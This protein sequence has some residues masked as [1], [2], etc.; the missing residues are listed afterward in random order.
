MLLINVIS[1]A[2]GHWRVWATMLI[3]FRRFENG[4]LHYARLRFLSSW[5]LFSPSLLWHFLHQFFSVSFCSCQIIK[6]ISTWLPE[7]WRTRVLGSRNAS[8]TLNFSIQCQDNTKRNTETDTTAARDRTTY[9]Y[10]TEN[11]ELGVF[12]K[13]KH[14]RCPETLTS[15]IF[16]YAE[17]LGKNIHPNHMSKQVWHTYT[18]TKTFARVGTF[19]IMMKH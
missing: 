8:L 5:E 4:T 3:L 9:T 13:G 18:C 2:M 7:K 6:L 19:V 1:V 16:L 15:L 11:P 10:A 12:Q 14:E 17:N